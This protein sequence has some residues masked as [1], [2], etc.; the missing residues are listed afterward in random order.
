MFLCLLG[1][2]FMIGMLTSMFLYRV[3]HQHRVEWSGI[4]IVPILCV[5]AIRYA[6]VIYRR[7]S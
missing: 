5:S 3:I 1:L 2:V 4:V 6:K 7:I